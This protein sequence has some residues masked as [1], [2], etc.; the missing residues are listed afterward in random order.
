MK[1]LLL[2]SKGQVGSAIAEI[3][4]GAGFPIGWEL[5]AW[6]RNDADF[7]KI[8]EVMSKVK[9][10]KPDAIFNAAAYTQVDLAEKDRSACMT[11]NADAPQALARYC[12][13]AKIPLMHFSTDY[14]YRGEGNSPHV[15]TDPLGALNYYGET[16][17]L[18]D[19]AIR[20]S[21]SDHLIFRTSWVFSE[22]G[23]SFLNTML[24]IGK[25]KSELKVVQD[26]IGAPS[27]AH[28]I[29]RY[30]LDAFMKACEKKIQGKAFPSGVYHL[31]NR[32][33]ASWFQF[34]KAILPNHSILGIPSSEYVTPAKR[35]LNSRLSL[36]KFENEFQ[37]KPRL[38][39]DALQEC[40]KNKGA[41]T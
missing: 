28:D 26:Q 19:E 16:K 29:A 22:S 32:G 33:E 7:L 36:N 5:I 20:T 23:K 13:E 9:K 25:E 12:A 38:W 40:L 15:E 31:C 39:S 41:L 34:A 21:G 27:Y 37:I 6:D 10:L 4:R 2:G 24:K 1:I 18:G 11:I 3:A 30:A 14:V 8:P 17:A 35:P